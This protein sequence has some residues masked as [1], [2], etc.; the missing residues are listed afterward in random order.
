VAANVARTSSRS[1]KAT[2]RRIITI[3]TI[4]T[5]TIKTGTSE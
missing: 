2:T 4:T 1:S 5:N 3:S